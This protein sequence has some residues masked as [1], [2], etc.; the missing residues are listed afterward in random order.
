MKYDNTPYKLKKIWTQSGKNKYEITRQEDTNERVEESIKSS[1]Y[2]IFKKVIDLSTEWEQMTAPALDSTTDAW[3]TDYRM[4]WNIDL[5]E[6]PMKLIPFVKYSVIYKCLGAEVKTIETEI[7]NEGKDDEFR[8]DRKADFIEEDSLYLTYPRVPC[9]FRLENLEDV[10]EE[11]NVLE[12]LKKVTMIVGY[13]IR[14]YPWATLRDV[15]KTYDLQAKLL[16]K[17]YNPEFHI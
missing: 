14:P 13:L 9:I 2:L 7:F 11:E 1:N 15:G 16:I 12:D 10:P 8:I 3:Y 17:I 6:F 4:Q 5:K